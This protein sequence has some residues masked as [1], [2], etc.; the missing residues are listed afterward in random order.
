MFSSKTIVPGGR[1]R[2]KGQ[3]QSFHEYWIYPPDRRGWNN[4]IGKQ[5]CRDTVLRFGRGAVHGTVIIIKVVTLIS[6]QPATD[7]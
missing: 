4:L 3:C 5:H 7:A 6:L 1:M 2:Q